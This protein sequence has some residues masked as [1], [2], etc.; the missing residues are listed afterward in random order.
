MEY[1]EL[2]QKENE[3]YI[4]REVKGKKLKN[5]HGLELFTHT[6]NNRYFSNWV[7]VSE[8]TTGMNIYKSNTLEN[9]LNG[10][11]NI[12]RENGIKKIEKMI[13]L[14]RRNVNCLDNFDIKIKDSCII[15]IKKIC[16]N[17]YNIKI[18][19]SDIETVI[20]DRI[21]ENFTK[22]QKTELYIKHGGK[23]CKLLEVVSEYFSKNDIANCF[24][25]ECKK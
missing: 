15:V 23:Y 24:T 25:K 18:N 1:F 6:I 9:A 8:T 14:A 3:I 19:P 7:S 16:I 5:K 2:I 22:T 4:K 11:E 12:I 10:L 21:I 13:E 17:E 20:T